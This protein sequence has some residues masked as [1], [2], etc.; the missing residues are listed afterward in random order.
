METQESVQQSPQPSENPI[1]DIARGFLADLDANP[2]PNQ[3][4]EPEEAEQQAQ[5]AE[6]QREEAE[7]EAVQPE[8]EEANPEVP[9][10]PMVEIE[11][12]D[13][14][15]VTV[16]E[17]LKGHFMRDKDYRQKT[18]ALA[19]QRKAYEQLSQQAQQVAVQAQQLAPYHAQLFAMDNHAAQ[20]QRELTADLA[21]NDP[22]AFNRKQGELAILLRNRDSLAG[23]LHQ[24][25]S[26]L[27]QH[28]AQL[29]SQQLALEAPKLF[30]EIP[31]LQKEEE[32]ASLGKWL[33]EQ[34]LSDEEFLHANY[35][36]S[37]TRLAW[38]AR[39]FD[40]MVKEQAKAKAEI[41]KKVET[42][43]PVSK[44]SRVA[45]GDAKSKQAWADWKKS[46]G[47][48]DDPNFRSILRGITRGK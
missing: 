27:Y 28:Q 46:G 21:D 29:K 26:A 23:G 16:P 18:M 25:M 12:D 43:P 4:R 9:E 36:V 31:E 24:Q 13:G 20:L 8:A 17:K 37:A 39:Q 34:G 14:E 6:E 5:Q 33:R 30:E 38:K 11:L 7:A 45:D 47:S 44:S 2:D 41:K 10:V 15:K 35:S 32:R 42:V 3:I 40:R 1:G 48:R 22:I 19:E